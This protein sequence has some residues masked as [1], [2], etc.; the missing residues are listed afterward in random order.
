MALHRIEH[1]PDY[2]RYVQ[3]DRDELAALYQ[4]VLI[5]VTSFF[6]DAETFE[7]IKHAVLPRILERKTASSPIRIWVTGC[8]SGEEAYSLGICLLEALDQVAHNYRIQIFGTDVDE[9][10]IARARRGVYP[11]NIESDVS[12]E[13]LERFFVPV[14]DQYQVARRLRD[15]AIFSPQNVTSDAPFSRIDLASCRNLFIYLQ[16]P[17]Q[18]KVLRLLHYALNPDGFLTLGS[19]ETVG[20]CADLFSLVDRKNKVYRKKN[21][22][23]VAALDARAALGLSKEEPEVLPHRERRGGPTAQQIADRKLMDCYGPPSV[24]ANE[25]L[26]VLQFR[27]DT[28]PYVSPAPGTATLNLL[29]LLRPEL[30]VEVWRAVQQVLKEDAPTR[31]GP[32]H[33]APSGEGSRTVAVDVLPVHEPDTKSRCLLIVFDDR[34]TA[35]ASL[36]PPERSGGDSSDCVRELEQELVT[37]K[38]YLQST[39]EELESSNEELKSTN[40]ELQSTNEEL[41]ST[42]EELETAKEELQSTNEELSTMN[43]ELQ[44]RMVDL[45]RTSSDS[46]Q[47]ALVAAE[48][49]ALRGRRAARAPRERFGAAAAE[50]RGLRR[51]APPGPAEGAVLRAGHRAS[52][53]QHDRAPGHHDG[54]DARRGSLVRDAY[55]ALPVGRPHSRRRAPLASRHR[56]REAAEGA[57]D[58]RRGV[59]RE[60]AGGVA[61]SAGHRRRAAPRALGERALSRGVPG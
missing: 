43:D 40:E 55:R 52:R 20:D 2:V 23:A 17:L 53:L 37:T 14:G 61:S 5:S 3:G 9:D 8:A 47:P 51:R 10:A 15:I 16:A 28:S 18:K 27:G 34:P 35:P 13:R 22:P 11:K 26:D 19:S 12:Q 33:L 4:D 44:H 46:G 50:A 48:P 54:G 49:R 58:R 7:F 36:P 57:H 45:T 60:D 39:V 42:N 32:L 38:E 21:L 31:V 41:Q 1:L 29:K 30:Q 6:R 56:Q 59:R 24:L 25:N